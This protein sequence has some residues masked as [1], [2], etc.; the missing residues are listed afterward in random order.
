MEHALG[1][2]VSLPSYTPPKIS[3]DDAGCVCPPVAAL[4]PQHEHLTLLS[5]PMRAGLLSI[6]DAMPSDADAYV[7]YWHYSGDEIISLLG[8]DRKRLG[9]PEDSRKRFFSMIRTPGADQ[10]NVLFT[11]TLNAEV[12][13]YSNLNR[14]GP[15]DN[16]AHLHTYRSSVRSA[17]KVRSTDVKTGSALATV[18][19]GLIGG[20][21]ELFPIRRLVL[22]TRTTN[23]WINR[24]LDLYALPVET[25][26]VD[27]PAGL[28]APGEQHLRYVHREDVPWMLERAESLRKVEAG[29]TAYP[30]Y[31]F[32]Q[33]APDLRYPRK[34]KEHDVSSRGTTDLPRQRSTE[35]VAT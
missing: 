17:L 11:I 28:A 29:T 22:Q 3:S 34:S 31:K 7:N 25:K 10:I 5:L 18:L 13:G 35:R 4:P 14:Y 24:A 20:Y 15:D 6:R 16:Y 8:I 23:R 1:C 33:T 26:Y 9:T 2:S 27:N 32:P 19:I 30:R 21:F 12:I